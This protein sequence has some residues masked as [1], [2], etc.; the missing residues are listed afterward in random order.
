[1]IKFAS[2]CGNKSYYN[3]TREV[4][5]RDLH[6]INRSLTL[7]AHLTNWVN[8]NLRHGAGID[9][10]RHHVIKDRLQ[11][12]LNKPTRNGKSIEMYAHERDFIL[13]I[14]KS[15]ARLPYEI[16]EVGYNCNEEICKIGMVLKLVFPFFRDRYLFIC[17]GVA[18]RGLKT[19][20]ITDTF[21]SRKVYNFKH[22]S[23]IN[24]H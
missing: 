9:I 8:T 13:N 20:Y 19:F 21:K 10:H 24:R 6:Y 1:M 7:K 23:F 2:L 12:Y 11:S 3:T 22:S 5:R 17:V 16:V 4:F 15:I 14:N 18:D